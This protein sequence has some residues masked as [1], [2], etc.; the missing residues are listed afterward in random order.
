MKDFSVSARLLG[1]ITHKVVKCFVK[2]HKEDALLDMYEMLCTLDK[3]YPVYM[4]VRETGFDTIKRFNIYG[5][6]PQREVTNDE[7]FEIVKE[8]VM[9]TLGADAFIKVYPDAKV[10]V[11]FNRKFD[12]YEMTTI[13]YEML[14]LEPMVEINFYE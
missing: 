3:G 13:K 5:K 8:D 1:L 9:R 4:C 14:G 7:E 6:L 2:Q 12:V 11:I 10:D